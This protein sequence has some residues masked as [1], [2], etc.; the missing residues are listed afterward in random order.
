MSV[1]PTSSRETFAGQYPENICELH[2]ELG[3][4]PLMGLDKLAE[5]ADF[6]PTAS[7]E[8]NQSDLPIGVD[9]APQQT[10]RTGGETIRNIANAKSWVMLKRVEQHPAYR[11]LLHDLLGELRPDIEAR[12]GNMLSLQSFIFITSAGGIT[13]YHFDPEHNILMQVRGTKVMTIY[14]AGNPR[15]APHEMHEVYHRGGGAELPWRD[16]FLSQ[17]RAVSLEPGRAVFVPVMSPHFVRNGPDVSVSLSI[18]WRSEWSYAEA[19]ARAFNG[20][21]RS[22]GIVPEP[23]KRWPGSNRT[24]AMAWRAARRIPGIR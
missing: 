9:G 4:H 7:V 3:D 22:V 23:T 18:T 8:C 13:P 5:L 17:G 20:L 24:K 10:G 14:P 2:H 6:L 12:T 21:L 15:F 11:Q 16:D 1:F 19:D